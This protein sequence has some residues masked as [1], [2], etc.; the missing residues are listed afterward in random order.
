MIHNH[1]ELQ[2]ETSPLTS[3]IILSYQQIL[4]LAERLKEE[5]AAILLGGD[6]LSQN[7]QYIP[8]SWYYNPDLCLSRTEN[9]KRSCE[10]TVSCLNALHQKENL[11]FIPVLDTPFSP[12]DIMKLISPESEQS[13]G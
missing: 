11:K 12:L 6:V 10:R 1:T 2:Y 5:N 7:D 3:E 8:T 9:I 4:L 13:G